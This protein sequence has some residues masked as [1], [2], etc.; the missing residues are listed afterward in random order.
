MFDVDEILLAQ[1]RKSVDRTTFPKGF[2]KEF[3]LFDEA[4]KDGWFR[5]RF[6]CLKDPLFLSGFTQDN[7]GVT[8]PI[9]GMDFQEDPHALLF[10]QFVQKRPGENL[11]L[12]D[13]DAL[14]KKR[15]ILWPRG[16]FKTTAVRVDIVQTILNYPNVRICFL[17]GGDTL[18][19]LQLKAIKQVFEKPTAYFKHLFP[20]FCLK[21][22]RNM[23]VRDEADP[24]AW[25]DV[26]RSEEHTSELQSLRH[27]VC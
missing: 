24:R 1:Y 11:V 9:L 3:E 5:A 23:R 19:K 4:A 18:A 7:A 16:I 8:I 20:E 15:M 21:S 22:V 14:T 26:L 10:S 12:S 25:T 2:V 13:L 17:T 27:L 6:K